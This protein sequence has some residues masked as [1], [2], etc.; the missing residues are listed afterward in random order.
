MEAKKIKLAIGI[1]STCEGCSVAILDLNEKI[2]DLVGLA[3]IV[4]WV[5]AM[6]FKLSDL[7]KF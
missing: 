5:L 7:E 4:Y 2:L 3:D 6:D 1:G